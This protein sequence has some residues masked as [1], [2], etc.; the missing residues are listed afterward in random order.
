MKY[1]IL[2]AAV[3]VNI[4]LVFIFN[5]LWDSK[6]FLHFGAISSLGISPGLIA[7]FVLELIIFFVWFVKNLLKDKPFL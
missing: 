1:K 7:L 4:L 5:T 6:G 3:S 2:W